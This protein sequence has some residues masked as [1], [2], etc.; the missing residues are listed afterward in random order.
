M[1]ARTRRCLECDYTWSRYLAF[2]SCPRCGTAV[3]E[4][5]VRRELTRTRRLYMALLVVA[6]TGG[7]LLLVW[8]IFLS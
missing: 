4:A 5:E 3:V 1:I 8:A 2:P 7:L 6:G